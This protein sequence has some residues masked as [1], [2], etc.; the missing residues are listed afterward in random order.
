MSYTQRVLD[1]LKAKYPYQ[2]EFLQA[3]EEILNT[4]QPVV[5]KEPK[6]GYLAFKES[7]TLCVYDI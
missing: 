1:S 2:P 5:D 7:N 4:L 3:A 6:Y